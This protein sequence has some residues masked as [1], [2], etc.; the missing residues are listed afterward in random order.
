MANRPDAPLWIN[1]GTTSIHQADSC[2]DIIT[3]SRHARPAAK[4]FCG[5]GAIVNGY[6]ELRKGVSQAF[7]RGNKILDRL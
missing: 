5:L 3:A 7:L 2:A 6:N 1:S 4:G